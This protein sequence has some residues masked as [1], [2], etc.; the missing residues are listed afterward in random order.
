MLLVDESLKSMNQKLLERK[1]H[2]IFKFN[3]FVYSFS[4]L[5]FLKL[6]NINNILKLKAHSNSKLVEQFSCQDDHF[7]SRVSSQSSSLSVVTARTSI[8]SWRCV[9][10]K[11]INEIRS[12][13]WW[14]VVMLIKKESDL[15]DD[16]KDDLITSDLQLICIKHQLLFNI[17][18]YSVSLTI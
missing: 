2:F 5:I 10:V 17:K 3:L 18:A 14:K 9:Y 15:K 1:A 16:L 7:R 12:K 6:F 11:I 13:I 4:R 8:F